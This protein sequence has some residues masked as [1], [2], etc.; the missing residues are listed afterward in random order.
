MQPATLNA[1]KMNQSQIQP[2]TLLTDAHA[3]LK[4]DDIVRLR[5]L[6]MDE[7]SAL[8]ES[9]C[10]AAM[11]IQQS[12][13]AAGLPRPESAPWPA[14]TWEFLKRHAARVRH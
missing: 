11:L 9:A 2:M 4:A 7:R 13:K 14:S 8:I 6:S 1:V 10:Q 5:K 3:A 12:R